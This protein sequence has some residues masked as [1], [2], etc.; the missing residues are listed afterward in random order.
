M[1][2]DGVSKDDA[3]E[4]LVLG[5]P[6]VDITNLD[7]SSTKSEDNTEFFKKEVVVSCQNM[8]T[9]AQNALIKHSKLI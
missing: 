4:H 8:F 6:T 5:A 9:T 2:L 7:T 3:F 1:C